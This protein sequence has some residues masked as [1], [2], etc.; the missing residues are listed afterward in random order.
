[1]KFKNLNKVAAETYR[2]DLK[3]SAAWGIIE[4]AHITF[5]L[6]IAVR[7]FN[8]G[9]TAKSL[10]SSGP[11][12]GFLFSPFVVYL[13]EK[14]RLKLARAGALLAYISAVFFGIATIFP[15]IWIFVICG[16]LSPALITTGIPLLTQIYQH[17]YPKHLRGQL[18]A[19]SSAIRLAVSL[20]FAT[21][22]GY[23][24]T[25]NIKYF[26]ILLFIYAICSLYMALCLDRFPS[27]RIKSSRHPGLFNGFSFLRSDA[28]FRKTIICWFLMG[29]GNL[30]MTPLRVEYLANDKYGLNLSEFEIT[31][32][33]SAVPGL[34]RVF[35]SPV[36]GHIFDR[37]N[38]FWLRIVVNL[39][40]MAGILTF[41]M[42]D[43][44]IGLIIGS[45]I[46]GIAGAGGD[47]AWHLWVTKFAP[48][49]RVADYMSVHTFFTGVRGM[50]APFAAF[51]L[52][53]ILPITSVAVVSAGL[54]LLASVL[55][56]PEAC[57]VDL[58][59]RSQEPP[60]SPD[61]PEAV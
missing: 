1:M 43:S 10:L 50:I 60:D 39:S 49:E 34:V 45:I 17:N 48:A 56:L 54:I 30:M 5:F 44:W 21:F 12:V 23:A 22:A 14:F 15:N 36:W 61:S 53:Q 40:F 26:Q 55:L 35:L 47:I 2:Y 13:V 9:P 24:L 28:V 51:H 38:F 8:A 52:I 18:F 19:V 29:L 4:T 37:L 31:I 32:F 58:K 41:F 27:L 42:S 57:N 7:W 6:I 16:S 46:Y 11:M 25:G 20:V 59:Q 3:R 33:I